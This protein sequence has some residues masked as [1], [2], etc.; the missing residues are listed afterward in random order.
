LPVAR[1]LSPLRSKAPCRGGAQPSGE[2]REGGEPLPA[3]DERLG[4]GP[5]RIR[6]GRAAVRRAVESEAAASNNGW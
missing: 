5:D 4:P 3:G 2:G 1:E 6:A